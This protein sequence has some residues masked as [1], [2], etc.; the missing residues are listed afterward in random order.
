MAA[1]N[2][3]RLLLRPAVLLSI[4]ILVAAF[5]VAQLGTVQPMLREADLRAAQAHEPG[6]WALETHVHPLPLRPVAR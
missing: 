5:T 2:N 1:V 4:W 6:Q 3:L